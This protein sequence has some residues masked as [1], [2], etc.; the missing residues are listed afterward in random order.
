M[1]TIRSTFGDWKKDYDKGRTN[2]VPRLSLAGKMNFV[3]D[4]YD[5]QKSDDFVSMDD[6][7]KAIDVKRSVKLIIN[8]I[9]NLFCTM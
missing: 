5:L 2:Y 6:Y 7:C 4:F 3:S 1:V 9:I 8:L